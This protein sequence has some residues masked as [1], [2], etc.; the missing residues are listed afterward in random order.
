MKKINIGIIGLGTVGRGVVQ[1]L[2]DRSEVLK[3]R[4][5]LDITVKAVLDRSYT[6]KQELLAGLTAS[7]DPAILF[8]DPEIDIILELIGGIE[9]ARSFI[10]RALESGKSVITA[11]KA[12]LAKHGVEI[13]SKAAEKG[14]HVGFEAAVAGALPVIK[15]LRRTLSVNDIQ[16]IYGILNGTCNFIITRMQYDGMDYDEAL[17][18]AQESGFAE[19]DPSFDVNG[20]DAAQKLALL[21]GIAFD[22][23]IPEEK[24]QVEG[25]S[26][27]RVL[28]LEIAEEMGWVVRLIA[29]AK[30]EL[31]GGFLLRVHPV[32]LPEDHFLGHVQDEKNAVL[33]ETSH[34]GPTLIMGLG[35][36]SHPTAA[37]VI[38]DI[39]SV[40][41]N[42]VP[43][44]WLT[45]T[46]E[47]RVIDDYTYRYYFRFQTK[48]QPGVLAE[49]AHILSE[50]RI[51][52]AS[53]H[54]QEGAEPVD[55]VV[56]THE[57]G[58][59]AMKAALKKIDALP[60][61]LSETIAIRI[62]DE[63]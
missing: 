47:V 59:A 11:N 51:S 45:S 56:I 25:I 23:F 31:D 27:I 33:F 3:L 29:M 16:E 62:L 55:V 17:R 41:K 40:A 19:A 28:D 14:C 36:G 30:K 22:N 18:L 12:L 54:Q 60:M 24:V 21:A 8:D 49:I 48:D 58:E 44:T 9:P 7:D 35:A 43:E 46:N 52:I 6:K 4:T 5:G 37:A 61:I 10:L 34:S 26:T 13:F 42:A 1:S 20:N 50:N 39:V 15:T 57:A 32:M 53:V 2:R 38:S 63:L